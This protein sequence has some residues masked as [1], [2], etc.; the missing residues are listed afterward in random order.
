SSSWSS[1]GRRLLTALCVLGVALSVAFPASAANIPV[2]RASSTDPNVDTIKVAS[3]LVIDVTSGKTL[4]KLNPD[5]QWSAASLTK[6]MTSHVFSSGRRNWT[7]KGNIVKSDEVG[8]G[9]L[10]V[11]SG[12]TMT[13]RDLLYSAVIGSANNAANAMARQSG[14]GSK[15]FIKEMNR[16]AGLLGMTNTTYVDASGMNPKNVSTAYDVALALDAA[17]ANDEIHTAMVSPTYRFTVRTPKAV[18]KTVKNTNRL[19]FVEPDV[20]VTAGKTGYL[21]ESMYNYT[22]KVRP[23]SGDGGELAIVVFGAAAREDSVVT[24]TVLAKWAWDSFV[25]S[26]TSTAPV[27]FV[28][29]LSPGLRG[30]DVKALQK[31]LNANGSVIAASGPGS[32]GHETDKYGPLTQAAV[33]K[34]QDAHKADILEPQGREL[35]SGVVDFQTRAYLNA[36]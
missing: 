27:R 23:K 3:L 21:E 24:A 4:F 11:P 35:G 13:Y 31:Y 7:A 18:V 6:L 29:N 16:R 8:G 36:H 1:Y 25:W 34:F 5:K 14:Y 2:L 28:R 22:V 12:S 33:K 17:G 15:G 26:G 9:R 10:G 20:L 30:A 19:L 32:P